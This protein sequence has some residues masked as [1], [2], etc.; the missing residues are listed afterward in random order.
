MRCRGWEINYLRS[1]GSNLVLMFENKPL[2]YLYCRQTTQALALSPGKRF[3]Q[4]HFVF[5]GIHE[6][7]FRFAK[8]ACQ[9]PRPYALRTALTPGVKATNPQPTNH[10]IVTPLVLNFI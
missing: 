1:R 7:L 8:V 4:N 9:K 2:I 5:W 10:H 6:Y 3:V